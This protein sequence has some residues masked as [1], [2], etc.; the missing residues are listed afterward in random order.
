MKLL[1]TQKNELFDVIESHGFSPNSF[2]CLDITIKEAPITKIEYNKTDYYFRFN[3]SSN[4]TVSWSPSNALYK[5]A[6]IAYNFSECVAHFKSWLG[7]LNRELTV[8]DK[9]KRLADEVTQLSISFVNEFDKFSAS[10]YENL[11]IQMLLL[12]QKIRTID[13][14]PEQLKVLENK[15]DHLTGIALDLSKF[16]WKGLF[17]GTMV[18]IIIQLSVTPENAKALWDIIKS[19][20]SKYFLL[21]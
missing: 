20:F 7:Y 10:E 12:K 5:E 6:I 18:S 13:L 2:S 8:I 19:I 17:V 4:I 11:K 1:I 21:P 15:I 9:W 16:D 14:L 3:K